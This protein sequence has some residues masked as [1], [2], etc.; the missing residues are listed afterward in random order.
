PPIVSIPP[1]LEVAGT[2]A[3]SWKKK[4]SAIYTVGRKL[5]D[6][7]M[8]IVDLFD[9][10]PAGILIRAYNQEN[11][12]R[13]TSSPSEGEL[14]RAGL[15]RSK[16]DLKR[17]AESISIVR[18]G[19]KTF[20][21][22]NLEGIKKPKVMPTGEGAREYIKNIP[23]G[24]QMLPEL[25]TTALSELCKVKPQGLEAV[26]WLGEWLI[27]NNP[28]KPRIGEPDDDKQ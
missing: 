11:S 16:D 22:S 18:V 26:R 3:M 5:G 8:Y 17:L 15:S 4:S 9:M 6:D 19:N 2:L 13:Y 28:N 23:A 12:A 21:Q 25:L 14:A 1:T 10:S 24:G 7:G 27:A 20:I